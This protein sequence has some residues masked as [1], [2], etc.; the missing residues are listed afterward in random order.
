M[1][2]DARS[3]PR[4]VLAEAEALLLFNLLHTIVVEVD[5]R[6]GR[7]LVRCWRTREQLFDLFLFLNRSNVVVEVDARSLPRAVL[8]EA[9][10][11]RHARVFPAGSLLEASR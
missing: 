10:A 3:L 6:S 8:A 7:C 1:E 9:E 2:V 4:A 5:A 11:L